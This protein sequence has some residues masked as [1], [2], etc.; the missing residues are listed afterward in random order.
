MPAQSARQYDTNGWFEV[1]NNPI[2]KVGVFYY[3]GKDIPGAPDPAKL[4]AVYRPAEELS[5]PDTL[6]SLKLLPWIDEHAMLG[7][8]ESGN[9]PAENKGV[10]G[11]L[12]QDVYFDEESEQVFGNIKCWSEAQ[13]GAID[14]GKDQ[15]SC[16]YRCKYEWCDGEYKGQPYQVIQRKLRGNHLALVKTGRM[17]PEVAVLDS[18]DNLGDIEMVDKVNEDDKEKTAAAADEGEGGE[19]V[20]E[21]GEMSLDDALAAVNKLMPI[22]QKFAAAA[23]GG[24]AADPIAD[25][26]VDVANDE[27]DDKKP[28]AVAMDAAALTSKVMGE[29]ARRDVLAGRLSEFVG[30]FDHSA[31]TE[32]QVAAYGVT[33]LKLPL[34]KG[35]EVAVLQGYLFGRKAPKDDIA[36]TVA[37]MDGA[38]SV[39]TGNSFIE[40]QHATH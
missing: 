20:V 3:L 11:V 31:M 36:I 8:E 7:S 28:A 33:K 23:S 14:S 12:G 35:Q 25:T 6:E 17:G 16:G 18:F 26:P 34:V 37:A 15:L 5:D 29:I 24:A 13:A 22:L 30:A 21:V 10:G 19:G 9:T 1:K 32:S 27:A 40:K 39:A 4:Y 2:S 38:V